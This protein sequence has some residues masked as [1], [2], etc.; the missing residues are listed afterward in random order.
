MQDIVKTSIPKAYSREIL[1][2]LIMECVAQ[3]RKWL[4]DNRD[5][6]EKGK[7]KKCLKQ[8]VPMVKLTLVYD[9]EPEN[10]SK[11]MKLMYKV[12]EY[13]PP[14]SGVIHAIS[15]RLYQSTMEQL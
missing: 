11:I 14:P 2:D 13:G 7:Y 8:L 9:K 5:K 6:L 15:P 1:Y 12:G 10:L 3:Y 4:L